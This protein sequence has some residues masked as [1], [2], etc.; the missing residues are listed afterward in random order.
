[1]IVNTARI[2]EVQPWFKGDWVVILEDGTRLTS[3]RTYQRRV[4]ALLGREA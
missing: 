2:R 3:G 4:R 1:V